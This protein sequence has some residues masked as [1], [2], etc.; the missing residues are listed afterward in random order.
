MKCTAFFLTA[1][2]SLQISG[3]QEAAKPSQEM[4]QRL[5]NPSATSEE[6]LAA[7][8]EASN[9]R[10]PRQQIIEAKLIWGLRKQDADWLMKILPEMKVLAEN[11]D[12][13]QSAGIKSA[14]D[15]RAFIEYTQGL[16]AKAKNDEA[17][18]K[19][20]MQE[21]F[22]LSPSQAPVFAQTIETGRRESKMATMKLDLQLALVT[23]AGEATTLAD[24]LAGKKAILLDFWASWCGPCMQLMPE[25][26]KK[27]ELLTKYGI[28]V[29]G[30]NKDDDKAE[31]VAEKV[32]SEQDINFPWLIE[33]IERPFT[34]LLE[35]NS[36]PC[37]VLVGPDGRVLFN[38]HPQD[39]AL[40]TALQ[41]LDP[42]IKAPGA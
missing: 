6:L 12:P 11:F 9:A 20:H 25:L 32:R 8:K 23:S 13:T 19:K 27:A 30:M 16:A 26:K 1:I 5:F 7:T 40:W 41:K 38:G 31:A 10:V 34:Q 3:A 15:I 24:Q 28:V 17:G 33:P 2:A 22:W 42:E 18:Y 37:M 29:A 35:I 4:M 14:D 36:I 39:P 21:A